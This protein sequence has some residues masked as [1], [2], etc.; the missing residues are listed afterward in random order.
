MSS[1]IGKKQKEGKLRKDSR[2]KS[3]EGIEEEK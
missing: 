1:R 3:S 2:P